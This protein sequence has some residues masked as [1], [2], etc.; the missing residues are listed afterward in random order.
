MLDDFG[1]SFPDL[2]RWAQNRRSGEEGSSP[3]EP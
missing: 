2:K 3:V 1:V